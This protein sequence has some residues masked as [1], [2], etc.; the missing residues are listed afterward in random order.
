MLQK[1][2]VFLQLLIFYP[3]AF[4]SH[5]SCPPPLPSSTPNPLK[6]GSLP[7]DG[8]AGQSW[9]AKKAVSNDRQ[10]VLQWIEEVRVCLGRKRGWLK[11]RSGRLTQTLGG[12]DI[13]DWNSVK[14]PQGGGEKGSGNTFTW[15][16]AF[17]HG[18]GRL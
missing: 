3:K 7:G 2:R 16:N 15:A 8:E 4:S 14:G 18:S 13:R 12:S 5:I 10:E 9:P 17:L 1:R 11:E 6:R